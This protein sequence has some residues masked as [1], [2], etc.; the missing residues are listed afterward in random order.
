MV[1]YFL[2]VVFEDPKAAMVHIINTFFFSL[3]L[4]SRGPYIVNSK[5]TVALKCVAMAAICTLNP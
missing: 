4:V 5:S 1:Q 2:R 3:P